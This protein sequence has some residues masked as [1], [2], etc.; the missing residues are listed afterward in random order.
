[1][2]KIHWSVVEAK[3]RKGSGNS[4]YN[5][6]LLCSSLCKSVTSLYWLQSSKRDRKH[7]KTQSSLI[8]DLNKRSFYQM[9]SF[10]QV[11]SFLSSLCHFLLQSSAA[12][13]G[14]GR[15]WRAS[16][17][18]VSRSVTRRGRV[19]DGAQIQKGPGAEAEDSPAG[20]LSATAPSWP[21]PHRGQPR[22]DL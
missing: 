20:A 7:C 10:Y 4:L 5:T 8:S 21:L 19:S 3:E 15:S 1:M 13:K 16:A 6:S 12:V 17:G 11:E 18:A 9:F 14:P 22:G 2:T